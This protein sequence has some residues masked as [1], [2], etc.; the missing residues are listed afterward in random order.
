MDTSLNDNRCLNEL[1]ISTIIKE[2]IR[3]KKGAYNIDYDLA[4]YIAENI[5]NEI[6]SDVVISRAKTLTP[7]E[8]VLPPT[9]GG[10]KIPYAKKRDF[11]SHNGAMWGVIF[12]IVGLLIV[13]VSTVIASL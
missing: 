13:L 12:G 3:E 4:E 8:V 2:A 6:P 9:H 10:H 7:D 1:V 11:T 5:A